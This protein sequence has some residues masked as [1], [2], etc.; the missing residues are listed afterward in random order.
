MVVEFDDWNSL[1]YARIQGIRRRE[2]DINNTVR[3]Y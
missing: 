3:I 1:L 2:L